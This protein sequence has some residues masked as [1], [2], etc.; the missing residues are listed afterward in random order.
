MVIKLYDEILGVLFENLYDP[1]DIV[2]VSLNVPEYD[3]NDDV[4]KY[5][6]VNL[7]IEKFLE[8]TKNIEYDDGYGTAYIDTSLRILM[9]D[10]GFFQR[11]EYDGS[12]WFEYYPF[13]D[14]DEPKVNYSVNEIRDLIYFE[15]D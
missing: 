2:S 1:E 6:T 14:P 13:R 11:Q 5:T 4:V 8:A 3:E 15:D 10:G 7:D 9:N 12:E